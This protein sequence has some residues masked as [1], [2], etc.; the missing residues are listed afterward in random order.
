MTAT[1]QPL[2]F[3]TNSH[4]MESPSY[5]PPQVQ[6]PSRRFRAMWSRSWCSSCTRVSCCQRFRSWWRPKPKFR[7]V[8]SRVVGAHAAVGP[9]RCSKIS[10]R[11]IMWCTTCMAS[12]CSKAWRGANSTGSN[13]T[14]CTCVMPTAACSCSAIRS[15]SCGNMW[16]ATRHRSTRWVVQILRASNSGCATTCG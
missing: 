15:T 14:S 13:A 8:A 3:D 1:S 16:A 6:Y 10:K 2:V 11:A 9:P 4:R 12:A 5:T 7:V